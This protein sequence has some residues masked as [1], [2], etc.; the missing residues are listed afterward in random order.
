M[1]AYSNCFKNYLPTGEELA[2][3]RKEPPSYAPLISVVVPAYET[4]EVFLREL[5]D[6]L[7]AQT[8]EN[9]ELCLADGSK[10]D[11]VRQCAGKYQKKDKRIH[12]VRLEK[13]GGIS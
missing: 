11:I 10:T 8:Y 12:Y 5:F 1:L 7:L 3:Q 4:G 2:R 9:W 6:S 13:N